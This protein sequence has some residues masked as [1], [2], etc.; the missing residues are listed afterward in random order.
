MS[1]DSQVARLLA[2]RFNR[3]GEHGRIV[4]WKDAEKQYADNVGTL[5]G[6]NA[7]N[8]TLRDVKLI[9]PDIGDEDDRKHIPFSVRYRMFREE[10]NQ[11]FLVYM[12]DDAPAAQ[13][14]WLLDLKLAYGSTFSADKLTMTLT[15]TL[16]DTTPDVQNAWLE[17]M[18]RLPRFF[19]SE[20]RTKRFAKRLDPHD[21]ATDFQAKM[22][23]TLLHL[24]D[25]RHSMQDIWAELLTQYA[26]DDDSGIS[27]IERMGLGE[28]HWSGTRRI[29]HF[30][31]DAGIEDKLTVKDF[32][33]W[34]FQLAWNGFSD[35]VAGAS[36]YANII[37]DWDDWYKNID[38]RTV[39]QELSETAVAELRLSTQ[40]ADMSVEE[41][42]DR[43]LFRDVDEMLVNKLF[44]RLG[45][46]SIADDQVPRIVNGRKRKLWYAEYAEQY[47]CI[48][49]ASRL[50]DTLVK[51]ADLIG[52]INSPEQGM[53]LYTKELYKAD[54]AYRKYVL[55]WNKANPYATGVND[56]LQNEYEAYQQDL[57]RAWQ[58][59]IDTLSQWRFTGVDSQSDFYEYKVEP[60]LK[61][62]RKIA[63]I[64][65]D[66]LR[67]EVAQ[68]LSERINGESRFNA[69]L[70]MQ[71]SVLPSYTQ[72]GMAALLPH[73]TLAFDKDHYHVLVDGKSATGTEN[74]NGILSNVGGKAIQY[75][76]LIRLKVSE[77]KELYK[78]CNV[79]Y[80]YHNSIDAIGDAEKTETGTFDACEKAF[81]ELGE[82]VKRLSSGNVYNMIITA[83]HGF[84]YQDRDL[85]GTE[86]LSEQPK[87]DEVWTKKRRFSIGSNLAPERAFVTF[88]AVQVGLEDP[89]DEGVSIQVP[90]SIMRL[91]K[92]GTGVRY[93]HGGA[94]LQEIVVPVL[95]VSKGRSAADDVRPVE[96]TILQR[97]DRLSSR[98]LTVEFLQNEPIE[99]KIRART[100]LAGLWGHDANGSDVL[101][102]NETPVAFDLTGRERSERHV[103]AT[104]MLTSDADRFN[105]TSIELHLREKTTGANVLVTLDQKSRYFFK[106]GVVA[107]DGGF[108]D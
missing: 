52:T 5:V 67:Y 102:S 55:A 97:T 25:D 46:Q 6:E 58:T 108:F 34:L 60:T 36:A 17:V 89:R 16:P 72:L 100:V 64:I 10:P 107:D 48:V 80:V 69:E 62:G 82:L 23:A 76:D 12:T 96:F 39:L 14:D 22:V 105:G 53:E 88:T 47:A 21:D 74:R 1:E 51:C 90:N 70:T 24:K 15:G 73:K 83:D 43:D 71:Y 33:L 13:D 93:V 31:V 28:F 84:L 2:E 49:A 38:L 26:N 7:A 79:L 61:A 30:D 29:Y 11:K 66:A 57:G 40:I 35:G 45:T 9:L 78:S 20:E 91:R 98:Q 59:Q 42:A 81:K 68:E 101:I 50:H 32:V 94:A 18:K 104:L 41:L 99:G 103:T 77:I 92:Q 19:D 87:G 95:H 37:R 65:S 63:V 75:E 85:D 3:P 56:D 54:G 86:W 27:A 44:E 4:F 8:E 106:Q